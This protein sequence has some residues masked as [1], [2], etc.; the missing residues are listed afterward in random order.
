MEGKTESVLL[1]EN[2]EQKRKGRQKGGGKKKRERERENVISAQATGAYKATIPYI[3]TDKSNKSQRVLRG[4]TMIAY[5]LL[6][7]FNFALHDDDLGP[8]LSAAQKR[9][10]SRK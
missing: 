9:A 6:G 3:T 2:R 5:N 7:L 1:Q 8:D 4:T 10:R